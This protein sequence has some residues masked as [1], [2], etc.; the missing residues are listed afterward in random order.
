MKKGKWTEKKPSLPAAAGIGLIVSMVASLLIT[1]ITSIC[2]MNEYIELNGAIYI[3]IIG[4]F[5]CAFT[6]VL[7][8]GKIA[9]ENKM[10][11]CVVSAGAFFLIMLGIGMLLFDGVGRTALW[12]L[13]SCA[14][15]SILG[16]FFIFKAQSRVGAKKRRKR[17]R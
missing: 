17:S 8:A 16:I 14:A 3:V 13:L 2:I 15:G 1:M 10:I 5:I 12:G 9:P 11:A 4:Q 7:T 6:G